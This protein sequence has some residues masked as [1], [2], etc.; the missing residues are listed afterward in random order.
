MKDTRKLRIK[1][2]VRCWLEPRERLVTRTR[3]GIS[4]LCPTGEFLSI[5]AE[6]G[7]ILLTG[8]ALG[9]CG[10]VRQ[11]RRRWLT[12]LKDLVAGLDRRAPTLPINGKESY[13]TVAVA[14]RVAGIMWESGRKGG[15]GLP[16][17]GLD[18]WLALLEAVPA[19]QRLEVSTVRRAGGP[20]LPC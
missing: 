3:R 11:G 15:R 4:V 10:I 14:M 20:A 16:R 9:R 17:L 5:S 2:C 12:R 1:S 7:T 19:E 13:R 8:Y 6:H 18:E